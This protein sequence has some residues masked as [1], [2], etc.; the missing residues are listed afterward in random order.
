M[1]AFDYEQTIPALRM[2]AKGFVGFF[3]LILII[4]GTLIV[5]MKR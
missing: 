5:V 3:G 2:L 4:G 1:V